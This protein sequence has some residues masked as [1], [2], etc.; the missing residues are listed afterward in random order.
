MHTVQEVQLPSCTHGTAVRSHAALCTPSMQ[1][2]ER[3]N[4]THTT[5]TN[6]FLPPSCLCIHHAARSDHNKALNACYNRQQENH[7]LMFF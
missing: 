5:S 6:F 3:G 7:M 1:H 2:R 4:S